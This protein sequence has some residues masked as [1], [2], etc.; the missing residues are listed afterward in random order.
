MP[1]TEHDRPQAAANTQNSSPTRVEIQILGQRLFL[2]S[3]SN[4]HH[5]EKLVEYVKSRVD[6]ISGQA[7][8]GST[9]IMILTALNIADDYLKLLSENDAFR[10]EVMDRSQKLRD[11][12]NEHLKNEQEQEND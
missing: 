4:P 1:E 6:H 11:M 10:N 5:I 9:K 3:N 8:L 7:H 12:L 2:K